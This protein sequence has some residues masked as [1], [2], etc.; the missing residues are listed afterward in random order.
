M[1]G[2]TVIGI[3]AD[4]QFQHE[5]I[6]IHRWRGLLPENRLQHLRISSE[7]QIEQ[8]LTRV[9]LH[10]YLFHQFS[11]RLVLVSRFKFPDSSLYHLV[12]II[13]SYII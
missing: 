9:K 13:P 4:I 8:S 11:V 3:Q 10:S 6:K 1:D 5:I 2:C 7:E 12:H